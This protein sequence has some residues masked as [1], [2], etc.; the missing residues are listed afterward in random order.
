MAKSKTEPEAAAPT[1]SKSDAI[2]AAVKAGKNS[3][4]E[5]VAWIKETYGLDVTT[6]TFSTTKTQ[7]KKKAGE[8]TAVKTLNASGAVKTAG[9]V[10]G[11]GKA[12]GDAVHLAQSV[13]SL[14]DQY[15]AEAVKGMASVFGK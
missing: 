5:G 4:S 10:T 13:K 14:V 7:D 6:G 15:G 12:S 3:P 8:S 2:R 9:N 11:N 1:I